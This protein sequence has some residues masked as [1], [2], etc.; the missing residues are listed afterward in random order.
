MAYKSDF[1][2][3]VEFN[4]QFG[5]HL[6]TSPKF[7]IFATEPNNVEFC[8][9]LIREEIKEL[10]DALHTKDY[11]E[12]IDA[13]ADI[14]YVV[15]GMSARLGTDMD[16]VFP[17]IMKT[18]V[19]RDNSTIIETWFNNNSNKSYTFTGMTDNDMPTNFEQVLEYYHDFNETKHMTFKYMEN[20]KLIMATLDCI[21]NC[22]KKL[23]K[24]ATTEKNYVKTI[25]Y[26]GYIL[27]YSYDMSALL[28]T[29]MDKA[30]NIVHKN[31]MSK[32]CST[33]ADAKESVSWYL[34]QKDKL[35]YESPTYRL[36]PDGIHWVVYNESTKKILKSIKWKP[37]D[38]T[39]L[40]KQ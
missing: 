11:I 10:N 28:E 15:M 24:Y 5:V 12:T 22:L 31:N 29:N 6:H 3:V 18:M 19:S 2:K 7:D 20:G 23:E 35:G 32:L 16:E 37:V 8:L 27:Y 38:L 34:S 40:Y 14:I 13:L 36:A 39:I 21:N 4:H 30:F 17:I 9:K 33:E 26:L 25:K 1:Q